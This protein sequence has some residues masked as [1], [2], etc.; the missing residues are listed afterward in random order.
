MNKT[1]KF[2]EIQSR[3]TDL[4]QRMCQ[5]ERKQAS[6]GVQINDINASLSKFSDE[7]KRRHKFYIT[8]MMG[9]G[10]GTTILITI[11]LILFHMIH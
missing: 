3:V 7:N 8:H 9:I 6:I 10:I 4:N 5:I 11:A 2:D 1:D